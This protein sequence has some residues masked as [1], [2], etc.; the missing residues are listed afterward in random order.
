MLLCKPDQFELENAKLKSKLMGFN[1][2]NIALILI[3]KP[4]TGNSESLGRL[5]AN[6]HKYIAASLLQ[7]KEQ[8]S[9]LHMTPRKTT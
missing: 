3:A 2:I 5:H 6:K 8:F 4:R 1:R 9:F 7:H